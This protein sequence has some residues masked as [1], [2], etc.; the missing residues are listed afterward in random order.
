MLRFSTFD[1]RGPSAAWPLV[2]PHLLGANDATF[3]GTVAFE[4]GDIVCTPSEAKPPIALCLEVDAGRAGTMMLQTCLL[5]QRQEPYRLFEELARHRIKL[6]LEK[7]EAWGLLDPARAPE[8]FE[9]F[10]RARATFVAGMVE[11][12]AFRSQNAFRDALALGVFAS[13]KLLMRRTELGLHQ[14]YGAQGTPRALGVRVPIEKAPDLLKQC[15]SGEFDTVLV[16]T[17]WSAIEQ[18]EGR[19]TWEQVDRWMIWAKSTR[20]VPVMGPLLD[21]RPGGVPSWALP[22]LRDPA[23]FERLVYEFVREVTVRYAPQSPIWMAA[24]GVN[25]NEVAAFTPAQMCQAVRHACVTI[26]QAAPASKLIVEVGDPFG[27]RSPA[28][29]GAIGAIQ[30]VRMLISEGVRFDFVGLP[31]MLGDAGRGTRDL[32]QVAS[33]LDRFISRNEMPPILVSALAAP[34]AAPREPGVGFWREPWSERSQAAWATMAF[35][36]AMSSRKVQVVVW[37][38]LR[39]DAGTGVRDSGLFGPG[40]APKQAAARLLGVRRK[41]REALGPAPTPS[42]AA[43]PAS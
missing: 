18:R 29:G 10:E 2:R 31:V 4:R 23:K 12:D 27:E 28:D 30:F 22:A 16:P 1:E 21:L 39:D 7:S 25:T 42:A 8:A 15:L 35:Q 40:G 37:D 20:R 32:M 33:M 34:S 43:A 38:R 17:P 14:R 6:F 3:A 24:A 41:M 26:R 11:T 36:V 19:F 13:E 5:Q 9:L